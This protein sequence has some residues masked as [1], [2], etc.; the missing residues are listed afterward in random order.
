VIVGICRSKNNQTIVEPFVRHH[1]RLLDRL[2]ICDNGSVDET[3]EILAKLAA[4]DGRLVVSHDEGFGDFQ[5]KHYAALMDAAEQFNPSFIV[6]LDADEF[7]GVP[8][9]DTLVKTLQQIPIGGYGMVYW[10]TFVV[11][12]DTVESCAQDSPEGFRWRRKAEIPPL[13]G[14]VILRLENQSVKNF[15]LGPGNHSVYRNDGQPMPSFDFGVSLP[16]LHFPLTCKVQ[17]LAKTVVH[18]MAFLVRDARA[19]ETGDDG[20]QSQRNFDKI[21]N[22][23]GVVSD[24][25][26]CEASLMYAQD[27]YCEGKRPEL[28]QDDHGIKYER[29]YSTGESMAAIPLI[30]KTWKQSLEKL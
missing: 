4:E 26:L 23:D 30:A 7:L 18:W 1:L 9:R 20:W 6:P 15:T 3:K 5:S 12:P 25:D 27:L 11:T 28:M 29:K 10:R 24:A 2:L 19:R 17:L 22:A 13:F 21:V 8:D 16:L 14:K